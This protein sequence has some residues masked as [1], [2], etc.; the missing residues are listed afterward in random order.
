[1]VRKTFSP[2]SS[3]HFYAHAMTQSSIQPQTYRISPLIWITLLGL[4]LTLMVPLPLLAKTTAAPV[5][6]GWLIA[7]IVFGGVVLLATLSEQVHLDQTGLAVRYP[8]W[9]PGWFRRGWALSWSDVQELKPRSTSQ[10]GLVYYLVST[11]GQAFLVPTRVVGFARMVQQI[12]QQ[13]GI[14]TSCV[15]PL[16][17]PWMYGILLG[18]TLLMG[19]M[20]TWVIATALGTGLSAR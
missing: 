10:G 13:T 8:G 17:Q 6:P 15:R 19:L 7:G 9:V 1:M 18:F 3:C 5:A 11:S 4:Y 16:A 20:D 14:D 12:Q 2:E